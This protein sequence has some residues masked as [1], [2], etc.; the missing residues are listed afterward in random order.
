V[1]FLTPAILATYYF[2]QHLRTFSSD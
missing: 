1:F 2:T